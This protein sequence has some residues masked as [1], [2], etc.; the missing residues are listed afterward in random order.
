[1]CSAVNRPRIVVGVDDSPA[2]TVAVQWAARNAVLRDVALTVV[3]VA[4]PPATTW[5]SSLVPDDLDSWQ[6]NTGTQVVANAMNTAREATGNDDALQMDSEFYTAITVPTLVDLS[7]RAQ[8]IVVG[9]RGIGAVARV[10][11]GSVS[12]ALIRQ[13]HCP[14]AVIKD[15]A[16]IAA[17]AATL[18][19]LVGIDGSPA[20]DAATAVAFDEAKRRDV[21]LVALHAWNDYSG[22]DVTGPNWSAREQQ[23][24][25]ILTERLTGWRER[26][27]DVDLT[28]K[29]VCDSPAMQ[30]VKESNNVQL[31][32]V[33][34]HGRGGF[35]G[36]LLGS[37]SS[38]VV[39]A[40]GV[41]VIV[42]RQP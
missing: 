34:S 4:A 22:C 36:M 40:V 17:H 16:S 23:A 27:P 30:L 13:A 32:V 1:M 20:S 25:S 29:V 33:G 19:V 24:K 10:V 41:P 31:V 15:D 42:A 9:S 35:A 3:H 8:L 14:V 18:P 5:A 21:G 6:L 38:A 12:S 11:L 2:S 26:Y 37:V 39:Q 28:T 7:K